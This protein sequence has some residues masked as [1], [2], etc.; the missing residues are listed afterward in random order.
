MTVRQA[1]IA[2]IRKVVDAT[3]R[4]IEFEDAKDQLDSTTIMVKQRNIGKLPGMPSGALSIGYVITVTAPQT[5][6]TKAEPVLDE[7]VPSFLSDMN[8]L[9]WFGWSTATKT[10][11][12]QNL[13]YDIDCYVIATP[14]G[15]GLDESTTKQGD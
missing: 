12:V 6:P 5:D 9:T 15:N 2:E 13:A 4:V 3:I 11:D 7:F 8:Q 10:L 1:L 14:I